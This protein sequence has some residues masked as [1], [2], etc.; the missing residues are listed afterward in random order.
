VC[1]G[2]LLIERSSLNSHC[3]VQLGDAL[4]IVPV[5]QS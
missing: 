2:I 5:W 4:L 3:V 1:V